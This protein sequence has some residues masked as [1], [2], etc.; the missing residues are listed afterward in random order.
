M[1]CKPIHL[2]KLTGG[3]FCFVSWYDPWQV[4]FDQNDRSINSVFYY[5][6]FSHLNVQCLNKNIKRIRNFSRRKNDEK[7]PVRSFPSLY[8]PGWKS[9]RGEGKKLTIKLRSNSVMLTLQTGRMN[10]ECMI[11]NYLEPTR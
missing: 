4:S 3:I 8:F 1:A 6:P 11:K 10:I 7:G 2:I 5:Y 9:K